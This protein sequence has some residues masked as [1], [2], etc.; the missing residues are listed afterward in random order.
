MV[1]FYRDHQVQGLSATKEYL[2]SLNINYK[3][4]SIYT[5]KNLSHVKTIKNV[6]I[7]QNI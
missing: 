3:P 1:G 2:E 4:D 5:N 7:V 6:D